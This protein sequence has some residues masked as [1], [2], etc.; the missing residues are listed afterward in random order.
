MQAGQPTVQ[1]MH[2]ACFSA[3]P[4]SHHHSEEGSCRHRV[5][6]KYLFFVSFAIGRLSVDLFSKKKCAYAT[7]VVVLGTTEEVLRRLG[8]LG[9]CA[10][11]QKGFRVL[12]WYVRVGIH[13]ASTGELLS[14][15]NTYIPRGGGL[16][17]A[18]SRL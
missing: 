17:S 1:L 7:V 18:L 2:H 10:D 4:V 14:L 13:R 12:L 6:H 5:L 11:A 16:E 9:G 8:S 3:T 15:S